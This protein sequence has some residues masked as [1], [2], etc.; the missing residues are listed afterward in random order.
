METKKNA[1]TVGVICELNPLHNGHVRLLTEARRL[2][3]KDGCVL[4]VMSGCSTQR[5]ECAVME[6]YVR[7][8]MALIGGADLVVE[9]PF[10]WSSGSAETF[11]AAGVY[12]CAAL[13]GDRLI[14]GSECGDIAWLSQGAS[15]IASEDFSALYAALCRE[16]KGT[17]AAYTQALH[18]LAE[19]EG[20]LLSKDFPSSNDLLGI[21]YLSAVQ[22]LGIREMFLH[23]IKREGQD[24]RDELLTEA[25]NPSATALR[26][27]MREAACDP[28]SLTAM[29]EGT[30]PK[31]ALVLLLAEIEAER[32]PVDMAP[33]YAYY[34]TRF[35]MAESV[36]EGEETAELG[37][38]LRA[39]LIRCAKETADPEAFMTACETKQ[40]TKAR[41]HRGMLFEAV[42][43]TAADVRSMPAYTRV[44]AV[45]ETGRTYLSRLKKSDRTEGFLTVTKPAHAPEGRQKTLNE[46]M[47]SLFSLCLPRPHDAGW[48][49]RH[50][51]YVVKNEE[52]KETEHEE[53]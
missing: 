10:P 4:C 7:A 35:R 18:T 26:R 52:R 3:G 47:D 21:A 53:N 8:R 16:G 17:A 20:L 9:L 50:G 48:L 44:L 25:E 19:R 2:A 49:M 5:G 38:G 40:Y 22:K 23:T 30:M 29:L 14:F 27:L 12:I 43:V 34:H 32:A 39:H 24:Y 42:G 37:G 6:P 33:L 46:R 11:A 36:A 15:L 41:L 45:N 51:P 1:P 31:P 28:Y 13:G